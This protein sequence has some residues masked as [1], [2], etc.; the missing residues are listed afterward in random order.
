MVCRVSGNYGGPFCA[1]QGM[2]QGGPLPAKLFNIL[3]DAVIREWLC[4]L[5]DGGIVDPEALDLLM[6]VFFAIFYMD[7]A[8]LAARDPDIL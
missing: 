3:V 2:T 7:D 4:Q 6:A 1:G 8:Y 5:R